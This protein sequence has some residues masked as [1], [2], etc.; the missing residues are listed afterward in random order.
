MFVLGLLAR[1]GTLPAA[2][3]VTHGTSSRCTVC[4]TVPCLA[5]G[6]FLAS[7]WHMQLQT[8]SMRENNIVRSVQTN[9][10]HF[11]VCYRPSHQTSLSSQH[12]S[13]AAGIKPAQGKFRGE[14]GV[15]C[16]NEMKTK[17]INK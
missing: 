13:L 14:E 12:E 6:F 11:F 3:S 7:Q 8:D 2:H 5:V 10:R 9:R 17:N 4:D 16:S 1:I 15:G